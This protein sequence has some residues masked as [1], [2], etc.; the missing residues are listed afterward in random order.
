MSVRAAAVGL[1]GLLCVAAA[2]TE[3]CAAD[4]LL[5][6]P[7]ERDAALA[8]I[9]RT[10]FG[11]GVHVDSEEQERWARGTVVALVPH[12]FDAVV[13][14][15]GAPSAWCQVALLHLNVKACFYVN[16]EHVDEAHVRLYVGRKRFQ[17]LED[18]DAIDLQWRLG[19]EVAD[20]LRIRLDG[21]SGPYGTRT[22]RMEIEAVPGGNGGSLVRFRYSLEYGATTNLLMGIYFATA[23]RNKVGFSIEEA[24]GETDVDYVRGFRGMMERNTMRFHL[25]LQ[26]YL[27]TREVAPAQRLD[28]RLRRWFQL[29]E[30]HPRQLR[31][32]DLETYLEMKHREHERQSSLQERIDER[33][34]QSSP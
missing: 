24:E 23:G 17:S 33:V 30:R 25:A 12:P 34:R 29:T 4:A 2:W 10:P 9:E 28:Q 27:D 16:G 1:A 14:A 5:H 6:L 21:D 20:H 11:E 31:E 8:A 7:E 19:T 3:A 13:S 18:T 32:L 26:A 22:F 15:L